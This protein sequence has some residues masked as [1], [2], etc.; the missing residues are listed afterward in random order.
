MRLSSRSRRAVAAA[1]VLAAVAACPAAAVAHPGDS[2]PSFGGGRGFVTTD[3]VPGAGIVDQ[4]EG[5]A[6][7]PFGDAYAVGT[8][9]QPGGTLRDTVSVAH[10]N[11]CGL[12]AT[13]GVGGTATVTIDQGAR[14]RDILYDDRGDGDITNDRLLVAGSVTRGGVQQASVLALRRDGG[15]LDRSWNVEGLT[16]HGVPGGTS[17]ELV[18]LARERDGRI[19]AAGNVTLDGQRRP[20]VARYTTEGGSTRRSPATASACSAWRATASRPIP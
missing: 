16:A 7:G 5:V 12:D 9:F 8:S 14:G 4:A 15:G 3:V 17:P 1:G 6:V 19:I 13:F 20:F 10:Y 11:C 18:A 2:D